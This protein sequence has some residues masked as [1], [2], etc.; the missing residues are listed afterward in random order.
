MRSTPSGGSNV[1]FPNIQCYLKKTF[2]V[3]QNS[4]VMFYV[5]VFFLYLPRNNP[6]DPFFNNF[7]AIEI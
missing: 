4:L 6:T 2:F 7:F 5:S 3:S 1:V